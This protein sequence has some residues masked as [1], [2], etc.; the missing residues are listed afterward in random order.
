MKIEPQPLET[1]RL[2][3]HHTRWLRAWVRRERM[4]SRHGSLVVGQLERVGRGTEQS[5][6]QTPPDA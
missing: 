1:T 2:S 3:G 5:R 4:V 6:G